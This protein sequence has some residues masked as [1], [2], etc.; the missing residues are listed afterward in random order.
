MLRSIASLSASLV[1][2][3]IALPASATTYYACVNNTSGAIDIV[4]ASTTCKSGTHKISWNQTGPAG[5]A[6]PK[7]ATGP[8]GPKGA[9]GA[10]GL[11]GLQG[12]AGPQGPAGLALGY[13][14]FRNQAIFLGS[15]Q[16]VLQ[17]PPVSTS[18]IYFINASALLKLD[19]ADPAAYCRITTANTGVNDL[20]WGGGSMSGDYQ[21]VSVTDYYFVSAGD[22][23][24]LY[25]ESNGGDSNTFINNGSMT[26]I[27]ISSFDAASLSRKTKAVAKAKAAMPST[28]PA[29]PR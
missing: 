26:S 16:I 10:T 4:S 7:G 8:A 21:Q 9:T 27:L 20:N 17:T 3:C 15:P 14:S 1:L 2:A 23:F 11:Q 5:P 25:C 18:G 29:A 6:G 24:Q 22:A 28:D 19:S 13:A 12:P